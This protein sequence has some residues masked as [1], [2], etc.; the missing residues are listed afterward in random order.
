MGANTFS[1]G[2]YLHLLPA[3][4]DGVALIEIG[5]FGSIYTQKLSNATNQGFP[6]SSKTLLS[7]VLSAYLWYHPLPN[8]W[9]FLPSASIE[10]TDIKDLEFVNPG[11]QRPFLVWSFSHCL[12][13]SLTHT[14]C[15]IKICWMNGLKDKWIALRMQ[16][17]G[18]LEYKYWL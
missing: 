9:S 15:W 16:W 14:K 1:S 5:Y 10:G 4:R 6:T 7:H 13:Q 3:F 12:A 2:D 17:K 11:W 18:M 8:L